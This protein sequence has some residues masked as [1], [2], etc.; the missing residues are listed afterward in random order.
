[1]NQSACF[2][3]DKEVLLLP[4]I[5]PQFFSHPTHSLDT[6]APSNSHTSIPSPTAVGQEN[7]V[8]GKC[9]YPSPIVIWL[10]VPLCSSG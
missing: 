5:E 6:V 4:G 8:K 9:L 10:A 2:G 3:K 1:M 7:L